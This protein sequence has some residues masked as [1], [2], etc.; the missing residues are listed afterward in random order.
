[1]E[2][3]EII[4]AIDNKDSISIDD[5][6]SFA[7]T[8]SILLRSDERNGRKII[9]YV[10]DNWQKI[11]SETVEIW[12]DLIESAGFY[13]YLEKEK[14]KLKFNNLAGEIRK[15]CHLS[16]NL[17]D[18]YF[19][20]EQKHL[21]NILDSGKN[22]IVSA[23]TSFGKSLLIEEMVAS[24][25]FKNI[26]VIQPTLALLDETRKKL[27][28]YQE[29][30]KIIVRTSQEASEEKG[31]L[32][33]L[34]AERVMEYKDLPQID[35]FVIDE[36][37]KLSAKRDDE[38]SDVLNNAFY[39]LLKNKS[40]SI[41]KSLEL[42]NLP[43]FYLLGPNIDNISEGF[44]KTFN[45]EFYKTNYSLIENKIEDIYSENKEVFDKTSHHAKKGYKEAIQFKENKLFELLLS[46]NDQQSIIYCSS[47]MRVRELAEKFCLFLESKGIKKSKDLPLAEWIKEHINPKW[48][49]INFLS[50][51]IGINDGALQKHINS[52]VIDYFNEKK[53]KYIF[54]TST[55]IE[56]VNTSAKNVIF[57]D[58]K[59]GRTLIDYFDYSNIKGR[60]GR[61]MIHYIGKIFN[62]SLSPKKQEEETIVDIP[63]YQQDPVKKEIT[64]GQEEED[65]RL[66]TKESQEY[67]ELMSIPEEERRLFHRN[68]V[69][70]D[71]QKIILDKLRSDI[72]I[73]P[74]LVVWNTSPTY[75][76]LTYALSL[77]WNNL[78][79]NGE[80]TMPMT[81]GN[82][83]RV[84]NLY[85][86]KQSISWLVDDKLEK[87]KSDR[88]WINENKEKIELIL[89]SL[90]T[91]K[92]K[93]DYKRDD[94]DFQK[95]KYSKA[96]F[97]L[98]DDELLQK[99]ITES[100]QV[101]RHWFQYKVPKW[102]SVMNEL[103]KY[104]CEENDIEPG[105]YSYY[106]SQ[107]ENDFI[108]DNLSILA[109]YGIP[110]SAINKLSSKIDKDLS[111]S[112]VLKKVKEIYSSDTNLLE[113]EKF[114]IESSL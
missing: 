85:G 102:L 76:Q 20:E 55:I 101:L 46:L 61:M 45:A 9:I 12:T 51:E 64:A 34:T 28:K 62:F 4:S 25:K 56:G 74:D 79:K 91:K 86:I 109:E 105:N 69:L 81:L 38:R 7:K 92:L 36:F 48:N 110:T 96:L 100:F 8:T 97:K 30:Y 70:I 18:K 24:N 87:Y 17:R 31:N 16:E 41:K 73:K 53:L 43:Q 29:N 98:S 83:I 89:N 107:I 90:T 50:F 77:A 6:F 106:A 68:G 93:D 94:L 33:L 114:K 54:C 19:H 66:K 67:K 42:K 13:P 113:Y 52:S 104:V 5:S 72:K 99:S 103:Q 71:G 32:F 95:Y 57:F 27:R 2:F 44:A 3:E 11:P 75:Q 1:M 22:L 10:L 108:R 84:T 21:K 78:L 26:V 112:D 58:D 14:E 60:S 39:R 40:S 111:E 80:T 35:F 88:D 59:K 15:G 23:P 63:F 82:L 47:P 65:I 37:Y 49:L